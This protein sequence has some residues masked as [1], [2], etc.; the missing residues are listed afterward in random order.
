MRRARLQK[1]HLAKAIALTRT[2][3]PGWFVCSVQVFQTIDEFHALVLCASS[4]YHMMRD[5]L[6]RS[7]W[8]QINDPQSKNLFPFI[9]LTPTKQKLTWFVNGCVPTWT[10][11]V[12]RICI[13]NAWPAP[14]LELSVAPEKHPL[15]SP[16]ECFFPISLQTLQFIQF[17]YS[18]PLLP[19]SLTS[20]TL[21]QVRCPFRQNQLPLSLQRLSLHR[22]THRFEKGTLPSQLLSLQTTLHI[23]KCQCSQD[24]LFA[25]G[26]LPASLHTL[27]THVSSSNE[28]FSNRSQHLPPNL[29]Q[30]RLT[31]S[32]WDQN[33]CILNTQLP[34]TLEGLLI[35]VDVDVPDPSVD[36]DIPDSSC[37][38]SFPNLQSFSS[39]SDMSFP[40]LQSFSSRSDIATWSS[41]YESMVANLQTLQLFYVQS[42]VLREEIVFKLPFFS[43]R[44]HTLRLP[45]YWNEPFARNQLPPSL[46]RLTIG[47]ATCFRT[48][49]DH[50]VPIFLEKLPPSNGWGHLPEGLIKF[51]HVV[52][53][54]PLAADALPKS[55]QSL[56]LPHMTHPVDVHEFPHLHKVCLGHHNWRGTSELWAF[57]KNT[58]CLL[59]S[60]TK[61]CVSFHAHLKTCVHTK[62]RSFG[63]SMRTLHTCKQWI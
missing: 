31:T 45:L 46:R 60:Y 43:S 1:Q 33:I 40:N 35:T 50:D 42:S 12:K 6:Q 37:Q 20:L 3:F 24:D 29:S 34:S 48:Y 10:P 17:G 5:Q 58:R 23:G 41:L 18:L 4:L 25:E 26:I 62:K 8:W 19:T 52:W 56:S 13:S 9:R 15:F 14:C 44:L 49:A 61:C 55:L 22:Y 59:C 27:S 21:D 63:Q 36:V 47:K 30:L 38:S 16:T 53:D 57:A 28:L 11:H 54:G 51:R 2:R 7:L 39:R 32:D